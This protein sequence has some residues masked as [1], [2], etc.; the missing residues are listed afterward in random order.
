MPS[1]A[2][3]LNIIVII[4]IVIIIIVII[5]TE[6]TTD[7]KIDKGEE[8]RLK[9]QGGMHVNLVSALPA[10]SWPHRWQPREEQAQ[11]TPQ[12]RG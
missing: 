1:N 5:S 11:A 7:K 9:C 2:Q 4:I 6:N 3:S 10:S 8:K 12:S